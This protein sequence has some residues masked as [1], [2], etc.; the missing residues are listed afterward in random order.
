MLLPAGIRQV[1]CN[2]NLQALL[3]HQKNW[4]PLIVNDKTPFFLQ[5][6]ESRTLFGRRKSDI[7]SL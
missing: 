4:E 5:S 6:H 3:Y 7:E 2:H 1:T